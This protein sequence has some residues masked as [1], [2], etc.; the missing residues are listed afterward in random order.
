MSD[1]LDFICWVQDQDCDELAGYHD[2]L[3]AFAGDDTAFGG[4][5]AVA[6]PLVE[7]ELRAAK[8]RELLRPALDATGVDLDVFWLALR[9]FNRLQ[10]QLHGEADPMTTLARAMETALGLEA[11]E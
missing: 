4:F 2:E 1:E 8:A 11:T 3:E 5:A 9:S 10:R 6:L 7:A